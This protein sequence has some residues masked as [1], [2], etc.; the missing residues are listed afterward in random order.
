MSG[1][2]SE[3]RPNAQFLFAIKQGVSEGER[4]AMQERVNRKI[5]QRKKAGVKSAATGSLFPFARQDPLKVLRDNIALVNVPAKDGGGGNALG[6]LVATA[7]APNGP[8]PSWSANER[9]REAQRIA[10]LSQTELMEWNAFRDKI[11]EIT[12]ERDYDPTRGAKP[13]SLNRKDIDFGMKALYRMAGGY[14]G[15]PSDP[16]YKPL[17]NGEIAVI[18]DNP[19]EYLSDADKKLYRRL[20]SKR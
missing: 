17:T 13:V 15:N 19:K 4:G 9:K 7:S 16:D 2:A 12:K 5:D 3:P 14:L 18:L 11:R 6:R 10:N 8:G 20:V 1:T